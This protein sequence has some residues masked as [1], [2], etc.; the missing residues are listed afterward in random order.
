MSASEKLNQYF[1]DAQ[2]WGYDRYHALK[3]RTRYLWVAL[4]FS[5]VITVIAVAAVAGLTP[6]K[7]NIP[8]LVERNVE[9]GEVSQVKRLTKDT[10]D[11]DW[12][13][14]Q[15][16]IYKYFKARERFLSPKRFGEDYL[17][18]QILSSSEAASRYRDFVKKDKESPRK[19][20]VKGDTRE[21]R[22]KGVVKLEGGQVQIHWSSVD[23]INK[24]RQK[25][26]HWI[27]TLSYGYSEEAIPE[28]EAQR[29][30]N[31]IGFMVTKYHRETAKITGL[32]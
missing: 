8:F 29:Y 22:I 30:E 5:W 24:Q 2:D 21:L 11:G 31:I 4:V 9:T 1:E 15:S 23:Y 32:E 10:F 20:F 7:E 19:L 16:Y 6:L 13:V 27:S 25:T 12:L 28:K 14:D 17:M 18:V 26:E 3:R